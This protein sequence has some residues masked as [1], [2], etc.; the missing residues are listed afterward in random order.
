MEIYFE[1]FANM[2]FIWKD[3]PIWTS[4][5]KDLPIWTL[6]GRTCQYGH[7]FG[8]SD[9]VTGDQI[10]AYSRILQWLRLASL[11]NKCQFIQYVLRWEPGQGG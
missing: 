11:P 4:I 7:L 8:R 2:A 5:W 3:L 6:I 1:G 9:F 10:N